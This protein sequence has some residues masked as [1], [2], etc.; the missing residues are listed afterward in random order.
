MSL[1]LS[2]SVSLTNFPAAVLHDTVYLDGGNLYWQPGF[3]DGSA[4]TPVS[5]SECLVS[6]PRSWDNCLTL[7]QT[8]GWA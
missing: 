3:Q 2:V 7:R 4:G 1:A 5:D 6:W 8:T